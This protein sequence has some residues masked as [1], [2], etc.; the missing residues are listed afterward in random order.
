M[1]DQ[2]LKTHPPIFNG[3]VRPIE[4]DAW[5]HDIEKRLRGIQY[6]EKRKVDMATFQLREGADD[7]WESYQ[8]N[9]FGPD[10][11]VPRTKFKKLFLE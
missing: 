2:F 4:S 1:M 8:C 3:T 7:W 10:A 9:Q 5:L 11:V 6:P